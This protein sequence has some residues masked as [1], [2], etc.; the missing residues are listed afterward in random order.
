MTWEIGQRIVGTLVWRP[1]TRLDLATHDPALPPGRARRVSTSAERD[2]AGRR[3]GSTD[4]HGAWSSVQ[5]S[6]THSVGA[7]NQRSMG[8]LRVMLDGLAPEI[9]VLAHHR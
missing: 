6:P 8:S 1:T 7:R 5:L 9:A 2:S 3:T 4:G